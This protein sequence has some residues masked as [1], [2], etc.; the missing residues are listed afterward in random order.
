MPR[1]ISL[2]IVFAQSALVASVFM[3]MGCSFAPA[4]KSF[5]M[6]PAANIEPAVTVPS[7]RERMIYLARQEWML[8]GRPVV[9]YSSS[10]PALV[11]PEETERGREAQP[12]FLTRVILY[13]YT[14]TSLPLLGY[15][16]ELRPWSGAFITWL[17]RSAGVPERDLPS[18]VLHWDYI[19]RALK[20]G[21]KARFVARN[22]RTYA[23]KPGDL[24]CAPRGEAFSAEV[25]HFERLRR[26]TFHCDLVVEQRSGELDVIGGNVLDAVSLTPVSLDTKGCILPSRDRPWLVVLEQRDVE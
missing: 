25:N 9:D 21:N 7:I 23:P 2:L 6:T 13:W 20:A 4:E 3:L 12:P 1:L 19:E 10:P 17:A 16:G 5:R 11:Y 24:L 15:Q 22:A 14:V 8:F 26:G 18:T